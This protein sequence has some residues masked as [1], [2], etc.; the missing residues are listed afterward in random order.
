M[1]PPATA[2]RSPDRGDVRIARALRYIEEHHLDAPGLDE[3]ARVAGLSPFHFHRLFSQGVGISPKRYLRHLTLAHVKRQLAGDS[4]LGAALD[5]GL[6]GPSRLHDLFVQYEAVT[7]GEYKSAG[8]G[9]AIRYGFHDGPF[10]EYMIGL[11]ERGLC[12]L[13]FLTEAD[14]DDA[15]TRLMAAWPR[16]EIVRDDGVTRGAAARVFGTADPATTPLHLWVKGTNFQIKVWEALLRVPPGR[17]VTYGALARAIGRP[18]SSRAVGQAIADNPIAFLIPCHRVIR[19]S[20]RF[21]D[22]RWGADR[23][24]AMIAWE[25]AS[26]G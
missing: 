3:V 13:A 1:T 18:A 11:T 5:A 2:A 23:K 14:H 4:V 20:G 10:G 6:S 16:A 7:P 26:A 8:A 22:Y 19:A 9:I 21:T 17:L 25:A 12:A 24:E 15:L